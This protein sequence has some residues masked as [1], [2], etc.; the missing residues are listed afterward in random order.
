MTYGDPGVGCARH[1]VTCAE[2]PRL[3]RAMNMDEIHD[4]TTQPL[5]K[6]HHAMNPASQT[7]HVDPPHNL[8]VGKN[9]RAGLGYDQ[10]SPTVPTTGWKGGGLFSPKKRGSTWMDQPAG[11]RWKKMEKGHLGDPLSQSRHL[12][13][14]ICTCATHPMAGA[15]GSLC[16]WDLLQGR[17]HRWGHHGECWSTHQRHGGKRREMLGQVEPIEQLPAA[18]RS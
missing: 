11:K 10:S 18:K 17:H 2:I 12:N 6:N 13:P 15:S 14:L 8:L 1:R 3:H 9:R 16:S 4:S 7:H 5:G